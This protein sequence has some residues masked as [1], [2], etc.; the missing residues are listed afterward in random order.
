MRSSSP[1]T[2]DKPLDVI[3]IGRAS[4]DLYGQQ[5]GT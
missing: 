3:T 5:I 1:S 2:G 4:V